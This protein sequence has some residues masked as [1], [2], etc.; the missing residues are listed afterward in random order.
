VVEETPAEIA[1]DQTR[2]PEPTA[3][4][5]VELRSS[6]SGHPAAAAPGVW[7][8]ADLLSDRDTAEA[9]YEVVRGLAAGVVFI[10]LGFALYHALADPAPA[11]GLVLALDQVVLAASILLFWL[12]RRRTIPIDWAHGVAVSLGLL[13]A[14]N[15]AASVVVQGEASDLQ[16]LQAVIV[17]AGAIAL[18]GRAVALIM[19]GTTA[20]ALPAALTVCRR[21]QLIDFLVMQS[22]TTM[23]SLALYYGRLQSQRKLL[24]LRQRAGQTAVELRLA[25][26]RAEHE[27][28][29]HE[30]SEE[31]RRELEE[32]LRQ[33]Q[34][35][36][37]LGTLAG[38]VAHDMNN[39][40]GAITAV[41]ST[42]LRAHARDS[43]AHQEMTEVLEAARRGETLTRNILSFAR[44]GPAQNAPFRVDAVV[45]SVATLLERTLPK[46]IVLEVRCQAEDCWVDGDAAQV[47][48]LLTNLGLNA[49]DAV[50]GQGWIR[51][52]TRSRELEADQAKEF[53]VTP[54]SYVEMSVADDG[55]GI[56][57][58]LLPRVFEP[59][60]STKPGEQHS[61]LGLSMVYGAVKQHRGGITLKSNLARGTTVTIVLPTRVHDPDEGKVPS[62][63]APSIDPN[64][65][66]LLFVDDEPLLRRAGARIGRSLGYEVVLAADGQEALW[67]HAEHRSRVC[68]VVLDVAM[69]VMSGADCCR[70]LRRLNP[71]L[72]VVLASGFPKD[73]DIQTLLENP[74]TRY[75]RKPYERD[76]LAQALAALVGRA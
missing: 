67:L 28:A 50:E 30:R 4:H 73:H 2:A 18:S 14:A 12:M 66:V 38:G 19:V 36:E 40:L 29:E 61:G 15:T 13:V 41:A 59:Y 3:E 56:A 71:D 52:T 23:L 27:F 74:R 60:F 16:Y 33:A 65:N 68:A 57:S 35:L 39:V 49:A 1:T 9:T 76:D 5:M 75:V 45:A 63:P 20:V 69:P 62:C 53:G 70:E 51:V 47:G 26:A 24:R 10:F 31:K 6:V 22:A 72:P 55:R 32:H 37:A 43:Q 8:S 54:G 42:A 48:H 44:R 7:D 11:A 34:R 64:R 58:E 25:L 17:G 46:R 21:D